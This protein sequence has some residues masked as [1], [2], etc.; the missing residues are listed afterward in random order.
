[1]ARDVTD[2]GRRLIWRAFYARR[3]RFSGAL[4]EVCRGAPEDAGGH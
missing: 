3:R 2:A 4:Q 1:M